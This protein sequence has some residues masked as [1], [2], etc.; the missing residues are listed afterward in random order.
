LLESQAILTIRYFLG[1]AL[2]DRK[3]IFAMQYSINDEGRRVARTS[4]PKP[5][6]QRLRN[7]DCVTARLQL[8]A[9]FLCEFVA[10]PIHRQWCFSEILVRGDFGCG[11]SFGFFAA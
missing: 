11:S 9:N 5:L 1:Q 7:L 4:R 8:E 6:G 3:S 10:A 2:N